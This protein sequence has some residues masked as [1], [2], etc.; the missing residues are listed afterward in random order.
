MWENRP[1]LSGLSSE[2][3]LF[4]DA[5]V[6]FDVNLLEVIQELTSLTYEAKEGAAGNHVL[7]VLLHMLRQVRDTVGE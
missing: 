7:L 2:S 3:Q 5:P 1:F 4:D 6:S